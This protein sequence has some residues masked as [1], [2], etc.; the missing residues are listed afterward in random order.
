MAPA[1]SAVLLAAGRSTRMG[2][3]KALLEAD[4]TPLWRHQRETLAQAGADE[5]F[6]SVR[7]EQPWA[8]KAEGFSGVVHDA[9][10]DGG[11]VVGVTAALERATN[12]WV[13]ALAIDLPKMTPAWFR[14][15]FW[16]C[17]SG[18]GVV[19]RRG[20]YFEPLAAIYPREVRFLAWE[21]IARGEYSFQR[22]LAAATAGGLM[23]VRE[24]TVAEA[25]WF[26]NWNERNLVPPRPEV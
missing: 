14:G 19:G 18:V 17:A 24:I 21:A 10:L 7:P 9:I 23:R 22:L 8:A 6:L 2:R 11:P 20:E 15:L 16:E 4:G 26:E 1:F 25:P 3:D 13:A 5:I 12:P